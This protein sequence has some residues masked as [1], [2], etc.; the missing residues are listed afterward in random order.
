MS[1]SPRLSVLDLVPVRSGQSSSQAVAAS[2]ALAQAADRLGFTRYWFA[3]HHNMPA[4]ASTTPPVLIA[5]TAARTERIR[6]GSGGVMLPN[7][8]PLVVAEQFAALEAL[9]PGRI[10]LGIGRA[11]G[12]NPV[13]TQ[14]LRISGP[15]A[16]VDRFPDHV[17]DILSLLSPDGAT[18]RLTS[19]RE[20]PI[21]ATPAATGVPELWLL[22]SSDYSARLA[23]ELGLPYVFANHFSGEGLE[24]ALELYRSGYRPSERHP[25]PQ[26]IL[27]LNASV[28]D[29]AEEAEDRALPQLRSMARLRLNRPMRAL[30]TVDDALA[31]PHD[32]DADEVIARMRP[33]WVIGDAD[34]AAAAVRALAVRHGIDEVMVAP[35]AGARADEPADAAPGRVR[36]L[37]LLAERLA[38]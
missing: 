16:D 22:G 8:A 38:A 29:S 28:A 25:A 17:A 19:G 10:D 32:S 15:T 31:A 20:Y 4:V 11:P 3:E 23:A 7:H 33:R 13:I 1:L 30:E 26:T 12:S 27:T 2:V 18:L 6:V 21:Q 34:A 14:L 36:T 35:I 24:Q 9:A 5:A 37:E